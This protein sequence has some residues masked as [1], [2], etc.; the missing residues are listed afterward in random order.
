MPLKE[1]LVY[2]VPTSIGENAVHTI[3]PYVV[4][5]V[6]SCQ[7]FFV[8]NER[9]ARRFLKSIWKEIRIDDYKWFVIHEAENEVKAKFLEE[10]RLGHTVGILSEAGT[11]G[12]ADP[13]QILVDAA[14]SAGATVKPHVGPK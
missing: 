12:V 4:E 5:A 2:L 6:K 13:G 8:E 1:S 10:L 7:S 9:S 14:Q 11:P 3:P